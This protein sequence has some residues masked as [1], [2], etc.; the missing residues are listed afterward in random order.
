MSEI[1]LI[2]ERLLRHATT[3]FAQHGFDATS[4]QDIVDA[5][6]VTKGA[7]YYYFASKDDL[8]YHI[9]ERVVSYE[10]AHAEAIL[11]QGMPPKETLRALIVDGIESIGLFREEVTVSLREMHRLQPDYFD[12]IK[13]I[14]SRYQ[15]F[16]ETVIRQGQETGVFRRDISARLAV[17]ALL[18]MSNWMYTW[19]RPNESMTSHD[20]GETFATL[21][22]TGLE[23]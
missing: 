9:H 3:L 23:A 10:T 14:R 2:P 8:L 12:K 15:I 20:I 13:G 5:A 18:G 16:F 11:A 6:N 4:V 17:L 1:E 7:F 22:L 21:L 19:Y